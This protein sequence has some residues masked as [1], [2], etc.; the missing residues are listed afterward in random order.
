MELLADIDAEEARALIDPA[1]RRM[2]SCVRRY[3]GHVA[4]TLGDGI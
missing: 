1:L 3:E 4:E 2:T